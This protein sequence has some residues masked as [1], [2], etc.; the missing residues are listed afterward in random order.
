[1]LNCQI[2]LDIEEGRVMYICIVYTLEYTNKNI[3]QIL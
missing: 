3:L 2:K 1:M